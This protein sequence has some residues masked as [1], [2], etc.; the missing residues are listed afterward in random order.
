MYSEEA[1]F[2]CLSIKP[3]EG[4][5]CFSS[6]LGN[7][8][9]YSHFKSQT[10]STQ[11]SEFKIQDTK[12]NS[13]LDLEW[14][15]STLTFGYC[16]WGLARKYLLTQTGARAGRLPTRTWEV[17]GGLSL[18]CSFAFVGGPVAQQLSPGVAR[19]MAFR[20]TPLTPIWKMTLF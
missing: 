14:S 3:Q 13:K 16:E 7:R 6:F 8:S 9:C 1:I 4:M 19:R 12:G 18:G 2:L 5:P 17:S 20:R 15:V 11:K 10:F